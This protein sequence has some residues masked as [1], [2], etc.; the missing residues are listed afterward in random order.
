[1]TWGINYYLHACYRLACI[2]DLVVVLLVVSLVVMRAVAA[3][4]LV[5][6]LVVGVVLGGDTVHLLQSQ[7]IMTAMLLKG[8]VFVS[9]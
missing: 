6:V 9:G 7:V 1:M 4:R 2:A 8:Q 3:V 5:V